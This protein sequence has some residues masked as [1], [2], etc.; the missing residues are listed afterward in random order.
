[1]VGA[2]AN[3]QRFCVNSRLLGN[4][5]CGVA[6]GLMRTRNY[7]SY[8]RL[9]ATVYGAIPLTAPLMKWRAEN[10]TPAIQVSRDHSCVGIHLLQIVAKCRMLFCTHAPATVHVG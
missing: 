5:H 9:D 4:R 6:V 10:D 3:T 7:D 8:R 2:A 1:M